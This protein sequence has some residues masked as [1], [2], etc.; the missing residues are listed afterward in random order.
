MSSTLAPPGPGRV[1]PVDFRRPSRIGRDSIV[2]LETTHEAFA[3]RLS[4]DWSSGGYATVHV[5]HVSTDQ[6]SIEDFVSSLPVPTA[7]ASVRIDRLGATGFVQVDL[8]FALLYCE[9][10]LGGPGDP[11]LMAPDRRATELESS[12]ISEELLAPAVG[13]IDEALK[14]LDGDASALG[15]LESAPQPLQLGSPGQLLTLLTYH[16]EIRGELPAQGM[17]TVAYPASALAP[18]LDDILG[19]RHSSLAEPDVFVSSPLLGT[20]QGAQVDLRVRLGG[21]TAMH[22]SQLAA[23]SV[24]DVLLLDHPADRPAALVLEG[25]ALGTAH[26]GRRRRKV[27]VQV[28]APPARP[29]PAAPPAPKAETE[30]P[31]DATTDTAGGTRSRQR[32]QRATDQTDQTDQ[33]LEGAEQ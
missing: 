32:R 13:A 14:E 26:I 24:D 19:A 12:L 3:R 22:A 8:P 10:L 25:H 4:A 30:A 18:R 20:V 16:V 7:L 23:L 28:D 21:Q 33:P 6:L 29:L 15:P 1:A 2:A 31:L 5:E 17:V 11:T 27:A 9:R